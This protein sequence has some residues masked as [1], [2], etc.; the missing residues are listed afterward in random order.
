MSSEESIRAPTN[1][2]LVG[3]VFGVILVGL[4]LVDRFFPTPTNGQRPQSVAA[5]QPAASAPQ[6]ATKALEAI[7]SEL[8]RAFSTPFDED[9]WITTHDLQPLCDNTF[10]M[11]VVNAGEANVSM[12]IMRMRQTP[13]SIPA[14]SDLEAMTFFLKEGFVKCKARVITSDVAVNDTTLSITANT[15]ISSVSLIRPD[16][17]LSPLLQKCGKACIGVKAQLPLKLKLAFSNGQWVFDGGS[18]NG[19][20]VN[21]A[22]LKRLIRTGA[23][24]LSSLQIIKLWKQVTP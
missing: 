9:L 17:K 22:N 24:G 14:Q 21:E 4:F 10:N 2:E 3:I 12:K 18:Y 6:D 1:L 7:V 23:S 8:K 16:E 15:D 5:P 20:Q 11:A 19:E 13:G